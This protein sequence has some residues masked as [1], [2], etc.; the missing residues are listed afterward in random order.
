MHY[1]YEAFH[2]LLKLDGKSLLFGMIVG[3]IVGQL[4]ITR[5][6]RG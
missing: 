4:I 5:I 6:T 2:W 3:L 1:L